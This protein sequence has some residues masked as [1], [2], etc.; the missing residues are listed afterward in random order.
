[1]TLMGLH[2]PPHNGKR[3]L[4][5]ETFGLWRAT[6]HLPDSVIPWSERFEAGRRD[7]TGVLDAYSALSRDADLR[8]DGDHVTGG[9]R[10]LPAPSE[11]G[12]LVHLKP[13][14]VSHKAHLHRGRAHE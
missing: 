5:P 9:E 7:H 10:C 13:N 6:S 12:K 4:T 3:R 2:R 1:M 11:Y 8:L 14:A